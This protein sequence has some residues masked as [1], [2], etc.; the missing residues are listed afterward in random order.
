M[1]LLN[2]SPDELLYS[3]TGC[4]RMNPIAC[5]LLRTS[6]AHARF[7]RVRAPLE[8]YPHPRAR[9]MAYESMPGVGHPRWLVIHKVSYLVGAYCL[10]STHLRI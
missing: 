1:R 9:K 8:A 3:E 7:A 4:G 2:G 6:R 10:V 5:R